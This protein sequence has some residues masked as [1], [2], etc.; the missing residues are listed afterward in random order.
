MRADQIFLSGLVQAISTLASSAGVI[1]AAPLEGMIIRY[2]PASLLNYSHGYLFAISVR[3]ASAGTGGFANMAANVSLAST[4]SLNVRRS[5]VSSIALSPALLNNVSFRGLSVLA[6]LCS[7][8]SLIG[9]LIVV[10][11][12]ASG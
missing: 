7:I 10:E 1:Y 12:S 8:R 3:N 5:K 11:G 9:P 6:V 4:S 2:Q